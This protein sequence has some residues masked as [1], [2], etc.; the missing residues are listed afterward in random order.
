[1]VCIYLP[2]IPFCNVNPLR[3]SL[4]P[5]QFCSPSSILNHMDGRGRAP[6][7]LGPSL[8]HLAIGHSNCTAATC[9]FMPFRNPSFP[10]PTQR[11]SEPP[12]RCGRFSPPSIP[13]SAVAFIHSIGDRVETRRRNLRSLSH[14]YSAVAL[15]ASPPSPI[16][17]PL[18]IVLS[19]P[20][21]ECALACDCSLRT[22]GLGSI[23]EP[24]SL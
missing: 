5:R 7:N 24:A 2:E 6:A 13:L 3:L 8:N 14:H 18:A 20:V 12:I 19:A 10:P 21:G 11:A 15:L 9:C 23:N 1:M 17:F 4:S 22:C 16:D